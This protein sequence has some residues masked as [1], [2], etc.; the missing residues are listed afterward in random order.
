MKPAVARMG[1]LP[2]R[3]GAGV[4]LRAPLSAAGKDASSVLP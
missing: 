3:F 4:P 2:G 1:G